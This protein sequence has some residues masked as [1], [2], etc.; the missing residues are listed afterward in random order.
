MGGDDYYDD[1]DE[2]GDYDAMNISGGSDEEHKGIEVDMGDMVRVF[3][4]IE[5]RTR[6]MKMTSSKMTE[7]RN[8]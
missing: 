3:K 2:E 6:K 5:F 8:K 7:K 4:N 1:Y